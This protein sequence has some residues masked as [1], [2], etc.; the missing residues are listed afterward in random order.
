MKSDA[1]SVAALIFVLGVLA[2][3][4]GMFEDMHTSEAQPSELQRG[5]QVSK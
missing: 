5:F 1:L 3:G 4:L 2:L